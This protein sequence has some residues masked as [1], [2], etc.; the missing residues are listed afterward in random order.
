[1]RAVVVGL[2][3]IIIASRAIAS[4][5]VIESYAGSRPDDAPRVMKVVRTEFRALGYVVEPSEVSARISDALSHVAGPMSADDVERA[6]RSVDDGY[7]KYLAGEFA[8]AVDLLRP[9]LDRLT[10]NPAS[11]AQEPSLRDVE[12]KALVGLALAHKRLGHA[13]EAARYMAELVRS[14]PD[15]DISRAVYGPEAVDL[16]RGVKAEL[17]RQGM[18]TL[19]VEVDDAEVVVFVNERYDA[20][21][22]AARQVLPGTYRVYTQKGTTPGRMRTIEVASGREAQVFVSWRFDLALRTGPEFV[23]FVFGSADERQKYE[24]TYAIA[25]ARALGAPRVVTLT[26]DTYQGRR[27]LIGQVLPIDGGRPSRMAVLALE[28]VDPGD[29]QV[30]GL[31]RFLAGGQ[32]M[33]GLILPPESQGRADVPAPWYAD[34]WGWAIAGGGLVA[35]GVG[36]GYLISAS[37]VEADADGADEVDAPGLYEKAE[38]ERT[39]GTVVTIVGAVGLAVGVTKLVLQDAGPRARPRAEVAFGL[40]WI[41]LR[42]SF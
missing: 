5:L 24:A 19:R 38:E 20:V 36:V 9:A 22:G 21:S 40:G 29:E 41:G 4:D 35:A 16:Y 10:A 17:E 3:L 25:V 26:I 7:A 32:A 39:I 18:G 33:P 31:A 27:A 37:I 6:R 1:M 14:F 28:P 8:G 12:H 42:G 2:V 15:K 30:R 23:G 13:D 34:R 11:L